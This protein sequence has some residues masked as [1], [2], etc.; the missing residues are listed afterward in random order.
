MG[1]TTDFSGHVNIVPALNA[2]QVAYINQ[3]SSTRRMKRKASVAAGFQDPVREAVGLPIGL[4]GEFYVGNSANAGQDKDASIVEYN[5]PPSTQPG[6][7]CQWVVSEDG[8]KLEWDE[9]EKFYHYIEWMEYMIKHFFDPW[10]YI[11]NG[12]IDWQGEESEDEGTIE[13]IDNSVSHG[14]VR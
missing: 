12:H 5:S 13:V 9:G 1:Y 8:T 6:L 2:A 14:V 10:G 3:F 7:W 11:L 4:E